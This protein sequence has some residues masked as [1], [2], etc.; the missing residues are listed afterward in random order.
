M[1]LRGGTVGMPSNANSSVGI[2]SKTSACTPRRTHGRVASGHCRPR[3]AA[4]P[5]VALRRSRGKGACRHHIALRGCAL[6]ACA[7]ASLFGG[8]SLLVSQS[9]APLPALL[10]PADAAAITPCSTASAMLPGRGGKARAIAKALRPVQRP[11]QVGRTRPHA[12]AG[13]NAHHRAGPRAVRARCSPTA[14]ARWRHGACVAPRSA[15]RPRAVIVSV[16][17]DERGAAAAAAAAR[18]HATGQR[19]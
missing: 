9:Q 12:R 16:A 11:P 3:R 1:S 19:R 10:P 18:T 13:P 5:R 4:R 15:A 2:S 7:R 6:S 17:A 8:I 14:H